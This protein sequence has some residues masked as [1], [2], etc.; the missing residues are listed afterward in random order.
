MVTTN[1]TDMQATFDRLS[2][3]ALTSETDGDGVTC[4]VQRDDLSSLLLAYRL[5]LGNQ[6]KELPEPEPESSSTP[7]SKGECDAQTKKWL[8]DVADVVTPTSDGYDHAEYVFYAVK[9]LDP[10]KIR[11]AI[12]QLAESNCWFLC[13]YDDRDLWFRCGDRSDT[14]KELDGLPTSWRDDCGDVLT[15]G[16]ETPADWIKAIAKHVEQ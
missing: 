7:P 9:G 10:T 13:L 15:Y 1:T 8:S 2:Q 6:N 14:P 11:L 4:T 3:A 12:S 5:E 16:Y